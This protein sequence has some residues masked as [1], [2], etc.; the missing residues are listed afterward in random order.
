MGFAFRS[1]SFPGSTV[2][3]YIF[4]GARDIDC[5]I[6]SVKR[7]YKNIWNSFFPLLSQLLILL[8]TLWQSVS[9]ETFA[10]KT[11][12]FKFNIL[13]TAQK[14]PS[15]G[16]IRAFSLSIKPS[17]KEILCSAH[18][19]FFEKGIQRTLSKYYIRRWTPGLKRVSVSFEAQ[20]VSPCRLA[21]GSLG[22]PLPFC[23]HRS[24]KNQAGFSGDLPPLLQVHQRWTVPACS[25]YRLQVQGLQ[26]HTNTSRQASN[27]E[28]S[29]G[30]GPLLTPVEALCVGRFTCHFMPRCLSRFTRLQTT[31]GKKKKL[32]HLQTQSVMHPKFQTVKKKLRRG[33]L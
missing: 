19:F 7:C 12:V 23:S 8:S 22:S 1:F 4:R 18:L 5:S 9:F 26:Y 28:T 21:P 20:P 24:G 2:C 17:K 30:R 25:G 31:V 16:M 3:R 15:F 6:S 11:A 29:S 27:Q 32:L 14:P 13:K 10:P 33:R